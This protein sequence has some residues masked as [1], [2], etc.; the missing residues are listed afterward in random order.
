MVPVIVLLHIP[1]ALLAT[2]LSSCPKVWSEIQPPTSRNQLD[3]TSSF[4]LY[5]IAQLGIEFLTR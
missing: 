2:G 4:G 1:V 3:L 5:K